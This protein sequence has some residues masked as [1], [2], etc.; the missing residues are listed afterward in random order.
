MSTDLAQRVRRVLDV[1]GYPPLP[2]GAVEA[3]LTREWFGRAGRL[4]PRDDEEF[5]AHAQQ[6]STGDFHG[7]S[8]LL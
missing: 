6:V 4:S 3:T 5:A 1:C 7:G 8:C 2:F